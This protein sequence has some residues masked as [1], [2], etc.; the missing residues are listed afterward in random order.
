M[1]DH[2][3]QMLDSIGAGKYNG[4]Y[5]SAPSDGVEGNPFKRYFGDPHHGMVNINARDARS[6]D[7]RDLPHAYVGK[8][9]HLQE[10]MDGTIFGNKT[11]WYTTLALPYEH[12]DDMTIS[13]SVWTFDKKVVGKVPH[14][15]VPRMITSS[16]RGQTEKTTRRGL[17]F[18]LEHGFWGT[19]RGHRNYLYNIMQIRE[20]VQMTCDYDVLTAILTADY[21]IQ[22]LTKRIHTGQVDMG[23]LLST[24]IQHYGIAQKD[25]RGLEVMVQLMLDRFNKLNITPN[26]LIV[27]PL[28]RTYLSM[29]SDFHTSYQQQGDKAVSNFTNGPTTNGILRGMQSV[30]TDSFDV[31]EKSPS[32]DIMAREMDTGAYALMLHRDEYFGEDYRTEHR[33]IIVYDE[34][35]DSMKT[36]SMEKALRN[37]GRFD[38]EGNLDKSKHG[39][40]VGKSAELFRDMFVYEVKE[41]KSK[42]LNRL[43]K[44]FGD[45]EHKYLST[46]H[47][48]DTAKLIVKKKIDVT[49]TGIGAKYTPTT[50]DSAAVESS[51]PVPRQ[52]RSWHESNKNE[53]TKAGLSPVPYETAVMFTND[54]PEFVEKFHNWV[55]DNKDSLGKFSTAYN[56]LKKFTAAVDRTKKITEFN[57][58]MVDMNIVK[59][60]ESLSI[61]TDP[62]SDSLDLPEPTA[63]PAAVGSGSKWSK[64]TKSKITTD[65]IASLLGSSSRNAP[66]VGADVEDVDDGSDSSNYNEH[67]VNINS[68]VTDDRVASTALFLIEQPIDMNI[69]NY[70]LDNDIPIPFDVM[71]VRP[72][73]RHRMYSMIL[74]KGGHET[75]STFIGHT[76][77]MLSDDGIT[78]MHYGNYTFNHKSIVMQPK[79]IIVQNDVMF[80]GYL[81]G[82]GTH[83]FS[84]KDFANIR[85]VLRSQHRPSMLAILIPLNE[86]FHFHP[87]DITGWYAND[88][89]RESAT[90]HY[91][92]SQYYQNI[93]RFSDLTSRFSDNYIMKYNAPF[94]RNTVI[95]QDQWSFHIG[96]RSGGYHGFRRSRSHLGPEL[97]AGV[98]GVFEGTLT[99]I[100]RPQRTEVP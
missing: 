19:P 60:G 18:V 86:P 93:Y 15:G 78:K 62:V 33:S 96:G 55:S 5:G 73:I 85:V 82:N 80:G 28:L 45:M 9:V 13:W 57:K 53:L 40:L 56:K 29:I 98:R 39:Y 1:S 7:R 36:I 59:E 68:R 90:Q 3:R 54:R 23:A 48:I 35:V 58:I 65:R 26:L 22:A 67:V 71:L 41:G 27:P 75:G 12:T 70:M 97:Y 43:C 92:S 47:I 2:A 88:K 25:P 77:M 6:A 76:N 84:E 31:Y 10:I 79:N 100:E 20:S 52:H 24:E 89:K 91:S 99:K 44:K 4:T 63:A 30:T 72:F 38:K 81:G 95:A 16:E 94:K 14:E 46:R 69:L 61:S 42:G 64:P 32:V 51:A 37:C 49:G 74:M 87:M 50:K 83:F 21:H 11:S 34:S 66:F 17:A 8:N